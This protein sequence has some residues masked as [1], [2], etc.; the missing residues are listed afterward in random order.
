M[1]REDLMKGR[2]LIPIAEQLTRHPGDPYRRSVINRAYYAAFTELN[3]YI[4]P[5]GFSHTKGAGSHKKAWD[6]LG[7]MRPL[8]QD[9]AVLGA[10]ASTGIQLKDRRTKAD[11]SPHL[12][13]GKGEAPEALAEAKRIINSLEEASGRPPVFEKIRAQR[14]SKRSES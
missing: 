7:R 8:H 11:Y 12:L 5:R 9:P 3:D 10:I 6:Y 14:R 4:Q 13:L 1:K 2:E